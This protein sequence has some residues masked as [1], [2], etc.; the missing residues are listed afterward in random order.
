MSVTGTRATGAVLFVLAVVWTA[1]AFRLIPEGFGGAPVT[2]RSFPVGL[3]V[4]LAILSILMIASTFVRGTNAASGA[5]N[6]VPPHVVRDRY[7]EVWAVAATLAFLVLYALLL[8]FFGFVVATIIVTAATLFFVLRSRSPAV[9]IGL[10]LG[11]TFAVWLVMGKLMGVYL[12]RGS[13]IDGF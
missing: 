9:L 10:P 8:N 5:A 3:G 11:L 13:I 7:S 1:G 12:P 4:L 6:L 2:P